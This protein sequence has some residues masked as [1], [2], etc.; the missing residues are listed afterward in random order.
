MSYFVI[1]PQYECIH[2]CYRTLLNQNNKE[3]RNFGKYLPI[4][5]HAVKNVEWAYRT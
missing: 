3:S 4:E 1:N 5:T 2:F